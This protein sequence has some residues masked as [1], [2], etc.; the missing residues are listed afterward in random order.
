MVLF[1]LEG[2]IA[3][4]YR[5][6]PQGQEEARRARTEG[7]QIYRHLHEQI[8][9]PQVLGGLVGMGSLSHLLSLEWVPN[10]FLVNTVILGGLGYLAYSNWNKPW[11]RRVVSGISV[12]LLTVWGGEG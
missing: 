3:E 11:D 7:A 10:L 8:M 2:Y 5:K 12:G 1:S 4:A 9:R 6:T